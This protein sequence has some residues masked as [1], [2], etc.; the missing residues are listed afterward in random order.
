[1]IKADRLAR[2]RDSICQVDE[3]SAE[4]IELRH[5]QIEGLLSDHLVN[6]DEFFEL[7]DELRV[8]LTRIESELNH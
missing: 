1:M 6:R 3:K 4:R 8:R 7:R 5:A 2:R